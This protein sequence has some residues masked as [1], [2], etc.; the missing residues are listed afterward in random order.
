[1]ILSHTTLQNAEDKDE[2]EDEDEDEDYDEDEDHPKFNGAI[3][4]QFR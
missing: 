2:D 1:M 3:N 4:S